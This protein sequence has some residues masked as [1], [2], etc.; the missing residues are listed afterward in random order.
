MLTIVSKATSSQTG[1]GLPLVQISAA[2]FESSTENF[3]FIY[4][5]SI[6]SGLTISHIF[7]SCV[8]T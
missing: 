7:T 8:P 2:T 3:F 5:F 1:P 4:K 6:I